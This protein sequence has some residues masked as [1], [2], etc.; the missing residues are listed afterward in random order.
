MFDIDN[1]HDFRKWIDGSANE[2]PNIVVS[3]CCMVP[4]DGNENKD[5]WTYYWVMP[6]NLEGIN[7]FNKHIK[8]INDWCEIDKDY[9]DKWICIM[10]DDYN[11]NCWISTLEETVKHVNR[12]LEELGDLRR[13]EG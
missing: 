11:C 9:V 5:Y 2:S 12:L 8:L 6:K 10:V 4:G 3:G 13:I 1:I 7:E